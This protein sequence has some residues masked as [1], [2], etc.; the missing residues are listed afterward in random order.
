[1]PTYVNIKYLMT[2][3]MKFTLHL[4]RETTMTHP[5]KIRLWVSVVSV[6]IL[7]LEVLL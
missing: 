3:R 4:T 1:M 6:S 7:A 2:S 5:Q